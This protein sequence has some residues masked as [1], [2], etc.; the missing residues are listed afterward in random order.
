MEQ[1]RVGKVEFNCADKCSN[2][3]EIKS[4]VLDVALMNQK[5]DA[6]QIGIDR[7]LKILD[8]NGDAGLKTNVTVTKT[9]VNQAFAWLAMLSSAFLGLVGWVLK[10]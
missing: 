6:M 7:V 10:H 8:G 4:V 3:A 5:Q 9:R 1:D 2:E